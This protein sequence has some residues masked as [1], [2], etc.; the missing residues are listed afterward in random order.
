MKAISFGQD[1]S[2]SWED[3]SARYQS[4]LANGFGNLASRV[5]AM[6]HR[7]FEGALPA[8]GELLEADIQVKNVAAAAVSNADKAIDEVAIHDAIAAIWTLVD[9]LNNYITVQEPWVLAKN[10]ETRE[11][12]QTVLNV[13]AEGL[14]TLAVL[15]APVTP[16]AAAKLWAA[17]G[18]SSLGDLS[19]QVLGEAAVTGLKAGAMVS[20]LEGLFPRIEVVDAAPN[21]E[22]SGAN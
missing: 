1:G 22:K 18:Q 6:V 13:A 11:R 2:F 14:K 19:A 3:L 16:K 4:E 15:M 21:A 17:L 12:L 7:Y 9:E 5:I 20:E 10:E 8:A